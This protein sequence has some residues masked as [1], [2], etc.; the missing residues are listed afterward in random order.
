MKMSVGESNLDK[1]FKSVRNIQSSCLGEC[2]GNEFK[3]CGTTVHHSETEVQNARFAEG[4]LCMVIWL[5]SSRAQQDL[6]GE[7]RSLNSDLGFGWVWGQ[8]YKEVE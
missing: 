6:H 4:M 7:N 8:K 3:V 2:R 1:C 5:F